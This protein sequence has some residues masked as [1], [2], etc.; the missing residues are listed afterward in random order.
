M[1]FFIFPEYDDTQSDIRFHDVCDSSVLVWNECTSASHI[2]VYGGGVC[3]MNR[4]MKREE[5]IHIRGMPHYLGIK[6]Y[7]KIGLTNRNPD[8][9]RESKNKKE[10]SECRLK[11]VNYCTCSQSEN[12]IQNYCLKK[13]HICISLCQNATL[14]M[15]FNDNK[16]EFHSFSDVS[17]IFPLWLVIEPDEIET[18]WISNI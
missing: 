8:I 10:A 5:K 13:F 9:I 18:I 16:Q 12:A 11:T 17:Q 2:K 3:F 7:I 15:C 1:I 6:N 14:L 4:P